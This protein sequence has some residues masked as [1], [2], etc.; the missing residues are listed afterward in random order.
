MDQSFPMRGGNNILCLGL[1][2]LRAEV[3]AP[4]SR[5]WVKFAASAELWFIFHAEGEPV[6][7]DGLRS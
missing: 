3:S 6:Q 1:L 5:L 7:T 2:N 4:A